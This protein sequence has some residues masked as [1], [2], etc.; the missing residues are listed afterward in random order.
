V[1][2]QQVAH[3]RMHLRRCEAI[4]FAFLS[5]KGQGTMGLREDYVKDAFG[6]GDGINVGRTEG[7]LW[8]EKHERKYTE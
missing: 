2:G 5:R 7:M 8:I 4:L 3:D 6:R 1:S